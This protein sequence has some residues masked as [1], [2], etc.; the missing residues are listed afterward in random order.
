[1]FLCSVLS[2][3]GC[4]ERAPEHAGETHPRCSHGC[5]WFTSLRLRHLYLFEAPPLCVWPHCLPPPGSCG[6]HVRVYTP[7]ISCS[8]WGATPRWC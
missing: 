5:R 6:C 4:T 8:A 7:F 1:M 3:I 2:I